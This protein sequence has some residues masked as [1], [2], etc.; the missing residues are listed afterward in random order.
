MA[1]PGDGIQLAPV[2]ALPVRRATSRPPPPSLSTTPEL[3]LRNLVCL[4]NY[5]RVTF[6]VPALERITAAAYLTPEVFDGKSNWASLQ[7]CEVLVQR[8]HA[9]IGPE[10]FTEAL[11]YRMAQDGFGPLRFVLWATTPIAIYQG[12][13]ENMHVVSKIGR[14]EILSSS[15]NHV[16]ARYTSSQ[17]ESRLMCVVRQAQSAALPTLWGLPPANVRE[18]SCLAH[19]DEACE[20]TLR[21][22]EKRRWLPDAAGLVTGATVAAV[23]GLAGIDTMPIWVSFPLLGMALG[24]IYE[25]NRTNKANVHVGMDIQE[26]LRSF[27]KEDAE[28]RQE[29]LELHQRQHEWTRLMEEQVNER[30]AT[31]QGIVERIQQLREE[32]ASTI[33]GFSHDLRNPLT[34]LRCGVDYFAQQLPPEPES[35]EVIEDQNDAIRR[36]ERLLAELMDTATTDAKLVNLTPESLVVD[37]LTDKLRRRLQ[38]LVH[39]REVRASVFSTREAPAK[40]EVDPLLFDRVIDNLLTNAGKYTQRGSIILEIGGTPGFL[41]IKVS[42]TGRGIS[43][44]AI[45]RIFV[46]EGSEAND[47]A[48]SSYGVGL[49]VVVQLLDQIGGRLEVMSKLGEGTTFWAHF[50][51][52]SPAIPSKTELAKSGNNQ[53]PGVQGSFN[54]VVKIRRAT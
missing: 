17:R 3:N 50:P 18:H 11:T 28:A 9:L 31:L 49:S 4:A 25:L 8:A 12:A 45:E 16:H 36:M 20:F 14:W 1:T 22:Y 30:T 47:R 26:A 40:V 41:T 53:A 15:R 2:T 24:R 13:L 52:T 19:G 37:T 32:R 23:C 42:D 54:R 43:P 46:P 35:N 38:A 34:V 10:K 21:W 6:G 48:P 27:A 29:I 7:Q 33:R 39:G 51:I 44:E 5:I